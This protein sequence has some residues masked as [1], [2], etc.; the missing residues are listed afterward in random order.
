MK[1][2]NLRPLATALGAVLLALAL[3]SAAVTLEW[4]RRGSPAPAAAKAQAQAEATGT[5]TNRVD[6]LPAV[7]GVAGT[8][9]SVASDP[10]TLPTVAGSSTGSTVVTTAATP[11]AGF[12]IRIPVFMYHRIAPDAQIGSSLPGLVV[13]PSRFA[14]QMAALSRA[15]WKTITARELADDLAAGRRPPRHSF[16]LTFDDGHVDGYTQAFPILRRY[17]FVGS[18]YVITARIG[19]TG[20]LSQAQLKTMAAAGNEIA[21]HTVRHVDLTLLSSTSV[22]SQMTGS[23]RAI[24]ASVGVRPITLAYP[25]GKWNRSLATPLAATGYKMAFIEGG[26]CARVT[27]STR[28]QVPRLR[29]ERWTSVGSPLA[30]ARACSG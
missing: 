16:V 13:S 22:R 7:R 12:A 8:G 17:G 19:H 14:A 6:G 25:F 11:P 21:S 1:Q 2:R 4:N 29:V 15:G 24:S 27:W 10:A 30:R 18:F 23:A 28:F 3:T 5:V 26:T 20:Y 9:S